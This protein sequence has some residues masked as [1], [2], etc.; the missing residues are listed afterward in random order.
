MPKRRQGG[1]EDGYIL[2]AVLFLVFMVLLTLSIA[3]PKVAADIERDREIELQ[4]RGLQ[5]RRAIQLY[6]KKFAAYPPNMEALEQSNNIRFL[7]KRY[8]DP[9]TGKDEWKLIHVGENKTPT[10]MG[11]FGQPLGGVAGSTIGGTGPGGVGQGLTNSFGGNG[12][13]GS[14]GI[15]GSGIGGSG[16]G[17]SSLGG[18]SFGSNSPTTTTDPNAGTTTGA[19]GSTDQSGGTSGT[20]S[21][22][23]QTFGAGTG[24][25]FG[26]GGI[27]GVESTSAKATILEYKKKKHFNEW[28]F[29]YD[30]QSE[31][32]TVSSSAGAIGS[33]IGNGTTTPSQNSPSLNGNPFGGSPTTPTPPPTTPPQQ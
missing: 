16:I 28:E 20:G 19:G 10:A 5:Y 8:K 30:P 1:G 25:T 23:A 3:A 26:G 13:G 14:S 21:T 17:G 7:R 11:F 31:R 6:Y 33:P 4:H 29:V 12:V 9:A 22:A 27:I 18:S 2:I 15:G 32:M 24:Q